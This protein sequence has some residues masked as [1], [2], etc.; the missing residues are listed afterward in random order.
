MAHDVVNGVALPVNAGSADTPSNS[1]AYYQGDMA[2]IITALRAIRGAICLTGTTGT[3][4]SINK[5][6]N[7]AGT[8]KIHCH[9]MAASTDDSPNQYANE[10][11]GEFLATS[12]TMDGIASHFHMAASGTGVMRSILGVAYLDSGKTLSG[13][14][15]T[16]SWLAGGVFQANV[17][18][19]ING[20]AVCIVG[21]YAGLGSM[22]GG[23]LTACQYMA[24]LWADASQITLAPSAGVVCAA[25]ITGNSLVQYGLYIADG[26]T[27]VGGDIRLQGGAT[28]SSG[29]AAP[30]HSAAQGSLYLRT[31]QAIDATLY[32]NTNGTTGW[33][34]AAHIS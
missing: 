31:G 15:S 29:S 18:G 8:L 13:T 28:I 25:L 20:T 24:G 23:T 10:F 7:N 12:G 11:K 1:P 22:V 17:A 21:G 26:T 34:L 32:I 33:T 30:T 5:T 4:I 27:A 2:A 14:A 9:A 3:G 19:V 16:G 6:A